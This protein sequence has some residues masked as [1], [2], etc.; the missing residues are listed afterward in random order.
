MNEIAF[1]K[2]KL[3]YGW[4]S[5]MSPHPIWYDSLSYPT[6]E[7]LFQVL[8]FEDVGIR[9]AIQMAR[10]PMTAKMVAKAHAD[11]MIV[12]PR[13]EADLANMRRVLTLKLAQHPELEAALLETDDAILIEDCSAR[14]SESGLFWGMAHAPDGWRGENQLG[15]LWMELRAALRMEER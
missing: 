4:L 2:V 13:S 12:A 7:A 5:N 6:G 1:T 9:A 11:K 15:K 3:P 14:P 10:S 8:R